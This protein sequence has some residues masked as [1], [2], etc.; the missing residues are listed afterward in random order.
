[1]AVAMKNFQQA[2]ELAIKSSEERNRVLQDTINQ[3][4][5]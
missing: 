2:L 3:L 5:K 4:T 1:M